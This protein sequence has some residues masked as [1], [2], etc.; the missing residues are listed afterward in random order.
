MRMGHAH[1]NGQADAKA[2][3]EA[4]LLHTVEQGEQAA[5]LVGLNAGAPAFKPTK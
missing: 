5:Y 2:A 1:G 4:G 3:L